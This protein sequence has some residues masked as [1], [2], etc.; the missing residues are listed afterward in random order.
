MAVVVWDEAVF[1]EAYPQFLK[2][3]GE[4]ALLTSA[5]FQQVFDVACLL[6]D[7][8]ENSRVPYDPDKGIMIRRTLLFLLVCHLATLA[9]WPLGQS[10]P[11]T[12]ATEGS[13]STGF[14]IPTGTGKAFYNQT[15]CGQA[16]WQALQGYLAG[17]RYYAKHY[18]HPWG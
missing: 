2:P 15:P 18:W 11:L 3:D 9:L 1:L 13:V 8:T 7:N 14:Q 12:T 10:G 17:G 4:T 16:Y 6:L 5:Q